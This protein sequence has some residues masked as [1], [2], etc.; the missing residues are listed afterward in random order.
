MKIEFLIFWFFFLGQDPQHHYLWES[1]IIFLGI[2]SFNLFERIAF[3]ISLNGSVRDDN[4]SNIP[5]KRYPLY[6]LLKDKIVYCQTFL[7]S[8]IVSKIIV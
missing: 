2:F 8:K 1:S 3:L 4:N 6:S 5:F 7:V